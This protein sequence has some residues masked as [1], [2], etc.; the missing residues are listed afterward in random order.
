MLCIIATIKT[1]FILKDLQSMQIIGTFLQY[2]KLCVYS[3]K[4]FFTLSENISVKI[5]AF[6][7]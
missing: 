7:N 3:D 1:S 6:I 4:D 2:A 5:L